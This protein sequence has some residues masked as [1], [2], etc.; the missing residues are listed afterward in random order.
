MYVQY[1]APFGSVDYSVTNGSGGLITA[2]VNEFKAPYTGTFTSADIGKTL[3]I[4][5]AGVGGSDF[6]TTITGVIS[7]T[8]VIT[9]D[10]IPT[11]VSNAPFTYAGYSN[12]DVTSQTGMTK[13][14]LDIPPLGAEI[15]LTLPREIKRNFMESQPDPRKAPE[16]PSLAVANS[17]QALTILYNQRVS[18]EAGRLSRQYTRVEAY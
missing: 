2:G 14:M 5:G 18:E 17:V 12:F 1:S 11:A 16:V 13:T 6:A 9:A 8:D 3:G 10:G 4:P 7:A 15:Q